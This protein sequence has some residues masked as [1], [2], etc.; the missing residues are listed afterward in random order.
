MQRLKEWMYKPYQKMMQDL[1]HMALH[2]PFECAESSLYVTR[3]VLTRVP[4]SKSRT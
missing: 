2:Q 3:F 4:G 1:P